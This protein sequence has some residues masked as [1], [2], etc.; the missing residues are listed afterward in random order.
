M[1]GGA[2]SAAWRGVAWR[3]WDGGLCVEEKK[4]KLINIIIK[5]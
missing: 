5:A 1:K 2:M 3:V 4:K